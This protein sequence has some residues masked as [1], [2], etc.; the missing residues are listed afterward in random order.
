[1]NVPYSKSVIIFDEHFFSINIMRGGNLGRFLFWSSIIIGWKCPFKI[2]KRSG[3]CC[4]GCCG[5]D[6]SLRSHRWPPLKKQKKLKMPLRKHPQL[7]LGKKF[8]L[9]V[10]SNYFAGLGSAGLG[11]AGLGISLLGA[12]FLAGSAG[13]TTVEPQSLTT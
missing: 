7:F 3:R 6:S 9:V 4:W 1:M 10:E 8:D 5:L 2:K 12:S 13:A 11:S